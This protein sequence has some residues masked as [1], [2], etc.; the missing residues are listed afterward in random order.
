MAAMSSGPSPTP[1]C[2]KCSGEDVAVSFHTGTWPL[3][4]GCAMSDVAQ[5]SGEHLHLHCRTCRFDWT[6][7]TADEK[8]VAA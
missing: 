3:R 5:K 7:A 4:R 2:A 1:K 8:G 6:E